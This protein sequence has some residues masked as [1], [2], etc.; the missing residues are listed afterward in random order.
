MGVLLS[1]DEFR[2]AVFDRDG[3]KCVMCGKPAVDAHHIVERR[4]WDD[5]G[6][7]I[8]NG[9][10]VCGECHMM[11]ERTDYSCEEVRTCANI[12]NVFVPPHLK[13]IPH[14]DK[15]GN[16]IVGNNRRLV[17]EL[18][19][20]DG[21][22]KVLKHLFQIF[23]DVSLYPAYNSTPPILDE[24]VEWMCTDSFLCMSRNG[25]NA[26]MNGLYLEPSEKAREIWEEI[27]VAIPYGM[28][29]YGTLHGGKL[30]I[31]DVLERD[32]FL[33]YSDVLLY[34]S[35]LSEGVPQHGTFK[36][37]R[38]TGSFNFKDHR[39]NVWRV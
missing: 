18:F 29:V 12:S 22:Q 2:H 31:F 39:Y 16:P 27:R 5:G 14:I 24:F 36:L 38:K 35:V 32:T 17:G 23:Y 4:L 21:V 10:S 6:Y 33:P 25:L 15:W 34:S 3:H 28:K 30:Y 1:R 9:A 20:D 13:L 37:V 8:D 11:C 26:Q 7:Y 19:Y